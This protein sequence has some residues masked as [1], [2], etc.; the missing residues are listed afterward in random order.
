MRCLRYGE[1]VVTDTSRPL[2]QV[3]YAAYDNSVRPEGARQ[4]ED[5]HGYAAPS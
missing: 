1:G 4:W 5:E 2:W 3:M